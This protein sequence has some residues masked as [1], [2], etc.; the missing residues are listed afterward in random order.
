[1]AGVPFYLRSAKRMPRRVTE[2]ALVLRPAPHLPFQ[3]PDVTNL[4]SN[5]LGMRIQPDEGI[6]LRFGAKVPATQMEV[7]DVT[8]DFAYGNSFAESS[9]EAYERLILDVLLGDPPLFP[10][11]DEVEASWRILDPVLEYW[12]TADEPLQG[13]PA[14]SWGPACGREMLT[15][16]GRTW[17]RP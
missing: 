9:P 12:A 1:M 17:R 13:Y 14:G 11:H 7:R 2:V 10:Q 16:D 5:A 4:G 6:M 3:G 8:M 15:R